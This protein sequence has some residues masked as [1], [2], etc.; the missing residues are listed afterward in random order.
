MPRPTMPLGTSWFLKLF[1]RIQR[2]IPGKRQADGPSSGNDQHQ[3]QSG[4]DT[5]DA[6]W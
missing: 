3:Q 1:K 5:T 2:Q 6:L 4:P